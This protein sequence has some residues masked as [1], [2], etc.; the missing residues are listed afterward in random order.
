MVT[1]QETTAPGIS[2]LLRV[3]RRHRLKSG[4][5]FVLIAALAVASL[6]VLPRT[7]ESEALL[8]VDVGRESVTLDPTVTTNQTLTLNESRDAELNSILEILQSRGLMEKVVD[9][10]GPEA[11]L[12]P[13]NSEGA[14]EEPGVL[15]GLSSALGTVVAWLEPTG[16]LS[17]REKA[18]QTLSKNAYIYHARKSH[19]LAVNCRGRSPQQAQWFAKA[20]SDEYL[21]E[22]R[23]IHKT[24]GSYDF[25]VGQ[26]ELFS[27]RLSDAS[28]RLRQAK[29]ENQ[30]ASIEGKRTLVESQLQKVIAEQQSAET[31]LA[32]NRARIDALERLIAGLP[33]RVEA[34]QV[35]GMPNVAGDSMR[36]LLFELQ[37]E[38]KELLSKYTSDHPSVVAVR[39]QVANAEKILETQAAS[40]VYNTTA[41]N[42]ALREL[43]LALLTERAAATAGE[44]QV[45]DLL[46]QHEK[47][48]AA[49]VQL[50]DQERVV[51]DLQREL[52]LA[53][54]NY[55]IY[56]EKLEQAR[57]QQSLDQQQISNVSITQPATLVE[58]PYSPK[59]AIVLG[60]GLVLALFGAVCTAI[61]AELRKPTLRD[62]AD[63]EGQLGLPVLAS[64]P[65][66]R[67]DRVLMN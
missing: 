39:D 35:A 3:V 60:A 46:A 23:R 29:S 16:P 5:V 51:T 53:D 42:P 34:Q 9:R 10:L 40:R 44:A 38:E 20:I 55:R 22:H 13:P 63:V 26:A 57:I 43:E 11:I 31:L 37:I 24:Q 50:N 1:Q 21:R 4:F 27:R 25:F 49:V 17:D 58:K 45:A 65:A 2:D 28:D 56:S 12:S 64:T 33:K 8:F 30:L 7:Y 18:I 48:L 61:F 47:A 36:Q 52:E 19:F 14:D 32:A 59:K 66:V 54:T 15:S 41:A 67:R 62:A 6:L